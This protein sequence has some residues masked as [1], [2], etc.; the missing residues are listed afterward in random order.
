MVIIF[1]MIAYHGNHIQHDCMCTFHSN[2]PCSRCTCPV[3]WICL[4]L[5]CNGWQQQAA[6]S[7]HSAC[8]VGQVNAMWSSPQSQAVPVQAVPTALRGAFQSCGQNC[9]G[10]ERF[11][12]QAGV[13]DAFVARVAET[14]GRMRQGPPL[15]AGMVDAGA[16]CL[17]GLARTVGQLVDDAVA[18]GAQAWPHV[19]HVSCRCDCSG[20]CS[21]GLAPADHALRQICKTS[22]P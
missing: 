19:A 9:A 4:G 17:P 21:L 18:K 11:I 5:P 12:V 1:S 3:I 2:P 13:H 20:L 8:M 10:A 22:W 7:I 6:S 16:M 14:A 15:G